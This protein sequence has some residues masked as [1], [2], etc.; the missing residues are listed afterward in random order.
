MGFVQAVS[1]VFSKY[2]T[3][4]GRAPRSEYWFWMLFTLLVSV[5]TAILDAAI[6]PDNEMGPLNSVAS[7][8]FLIPGFSVCARRLHDTGRSGWWSL[9]FLVPLIGW[10]I[11]LIWTVSKSEPI[12]NEYGPPPLP[13]A[14]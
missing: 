14:A 9:L 10:L 8:A 5:A 2:A 1:S 13:V 7:L 4:A 12:D 3:F 11:L 6:F